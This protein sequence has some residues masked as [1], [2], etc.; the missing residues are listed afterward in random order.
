MALTYGSILILG[1]PSGLLGVTKVW[2]A[3]SAL[4]ISTHLHHFRYETL[5][6]FAPDLQVAAVRGPLDFYS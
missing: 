2:L 5:R 4:P 1:L 3:K 6:K